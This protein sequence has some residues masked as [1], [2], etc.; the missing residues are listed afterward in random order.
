[1]IERTIRHKKIS[2]AVLVSLCERFHY[3]VNL[4]GFAGKA[5]VHKQFAE[6]NIERI[7]EEVKLFDICLESLSEKGIPA[8][9]KLS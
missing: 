7:A 5:D 8:A 6:C 3:T 9:R 2:V 1:M 4:L